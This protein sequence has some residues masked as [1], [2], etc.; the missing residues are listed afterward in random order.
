MTDLSS[1]PTAAWQR[2]RHR[3]GGCLLMIACAEGLHRGMT[4]SVSVEDTDRVMPSP[5]RELEYGPVT[6]HTLS[7]A[8]HLIRRSTYPV[9]RPLLT[10]RRPS[11]RIDA[12]HLDDLD[13]TGFTTPGAAAAWISPLGLL[14]RLP[15]SEVAE[16]A[17]RTAARC[18]ADH[19]AQDIAAA[20]A[21][22]VAVAALQEPGRPPH[23]DHLIAT[24]AAHTDTVP[25]RR[26]LQTVRALVGRPLNSE[27]NVAEM[28]GEPAVTAFAVAL[29]LY[30]TC[31]REPH[32][33][34]RRAMLAPASDAT[35][36]TAA[37][38]GA[39]GGDDLVPTEWGARLRSSLRVWSVAGELAELVTHAAPQR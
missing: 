26:A 13:V 3:V 25:L 8:V 5:T 16:A 12:L 2:W 14:P 36:M 22:A 38:L 15:L 37:L 7:L 28:A 24:I 10:G 33:A 27:D 17:R 34:L 6:G 18:G 23:V 4:A 20:Q 9:T 19:T 32:P 35:V 1:N 30:L 31:Y 21:V 39:H 29:R 11:H